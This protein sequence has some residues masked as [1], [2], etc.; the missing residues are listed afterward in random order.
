MF[1]T[2]C[3]VPV[4]LTVIALGLITLGCKTSSPDPSPNTDST[5]AISL[6]EDLADQVIALHQAARDSFALRLDRAKLDE[7]IATW[8]EALALL[9]DPGVAP[10]TH[11]T[12]LED[13][14]HAYYFRAHFHHART[15]P[16]LLEEL[17]IDTTR[18]LNLAREALLTRDRELATLLA[19]TSF[20]PATADLDLSSVHTDNA[21]ALLSYAQ[22]LHLRAQHQNLSALLEV[23]PFLDAAYTHL[24]NTAPHLQFG[25]PHRY[26]GD[27]WIQRPFGK[28]ATASARAYES[29]LHLA[30]DYLPTRVERAEN[31]AIETADR[32]LF[33][34]D[35]EYVLNAS[36]QALPQAEPEN[37]LAQLQARILLEKAD[38]LF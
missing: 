10:E 16:P 28:D 9:N 24:L 6:E 22:H 32:E 30:P 31:L 33:Q 14:S 8:E 36:P 29:A 38:L 37:I 35:L 21:Q 5:A 17:R 7:A 12:I 13:L 11:L 18:G 3:A 15:A 26:F 23:E 2:R 27:R 19:Q 25:E 20:N 1:S 34:A 4:L